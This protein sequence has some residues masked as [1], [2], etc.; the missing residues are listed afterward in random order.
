[1]V[2]ICRSHFPIDREHRLTDEAYFAFCVATNPD[3][4]VELTSEGEIFIVPPPGGE[5]DF[6][7]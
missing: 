6:R 7:T 5:S 2:E 4:N 1:M 3:L